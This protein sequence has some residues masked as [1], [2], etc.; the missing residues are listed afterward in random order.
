[1]AC[2]DIGTIAQILREKNE[3]KRAKILRKRER[4]QHM[5]SLPKENLRLQEQMLEEEAMMEELKIAN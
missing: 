1:M 2:S 3:E 4:Q 5:L